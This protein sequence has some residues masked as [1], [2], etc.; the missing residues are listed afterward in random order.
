MNACLYIYINTVY[1]L[2]DIMF[3][4]SFFVNEFIFILINTLIKTN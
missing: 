4:I 1:D 3:L 2:P